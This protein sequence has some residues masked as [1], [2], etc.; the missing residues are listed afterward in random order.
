MPPEPVKRPDHLGAS[1]RHDLSRAMQKCAPM[2]TL[3][4]TTTTATGGKYVFSMLEPVSGA[5]DDCYR[6][7]FV[8]PAGVAFS[9]RQQGEKR[10]PRDRHGRSAASVARLS[11][12]R[13]TCRL[14]HACIRE[15]SVRQ[16]GSG[17]VGSLVVMRIGAG[18]FR[19][20][21][22]EIGLEIGADLAGRVF[23]DQQR[24]RSVPAEESE[25][26][27]VD[28]LATAPILHRAGDF[29][30]CL[31]LG[32]DLEGSGRLAHCGHL[33]SRGVRAI[34]ASSARAAR[35]VEGGTRKDPI[36][37]EQET[38]E[39]AAEGA[40]EAPIPSLAEMQHWTWVMGRA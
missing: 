23:L 37:A 24:R 2:T 36:M 3:L 21:P 13:I 4:R 17:V 35:W 18:R 11:G 19:S 16:V 7:Q 38:S 32:L 31:P 12:A 29:D 14:E 20:Y 1:R 34:L 9:P 26:A 6:V 28:C 15:S 27:L 30:E 33:A 25:Q 8:A 22:R 39:P 5:A 40:P 10:R